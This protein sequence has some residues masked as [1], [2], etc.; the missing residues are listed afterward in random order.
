MGAGVGAAGFGETVGSAS[1]ELASREKRTLPGGGWSACG[2]GDC[3]ASASA[4]PR[5]RVRMTAKD[6]Q[7]RVTSRVLCGAWRARRIWDSG[8][9]APGGCAGASLRT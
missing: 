4:T 3:C 5:A 9:S 7:A 1:G 6:E 8:L 2:A